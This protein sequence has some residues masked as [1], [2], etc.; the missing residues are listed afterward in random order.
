MRHGENTKLIFDVFFMF[1]ILVEAP[2]AA[3]LRYGGV[4][5]QRGCVWSPAAAPED[6][7]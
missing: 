7:A 2:V 6:P 4:G 5:Q 3:V 1:F